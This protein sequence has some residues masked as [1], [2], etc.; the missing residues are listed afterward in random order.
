MTLATPALAVHVTPR[1]RQLR[2][3]WLTVH[4]WTA[5]SVGW[6]LALVGLVGAVLI[7]GQ[8]VD[9]WLHPA[10]FKAQPAAASA[11]PATLE[12]IRR[13]LVAEFGKASLRL[14]PPVEPGDTLAV[15]V[16]SAAWDGTVYLHPLTGREQG[17][18]GELEGVVNFLFKFHSSLLLKDTGKATLAAISLT[19]LV[20]LVTGLLLWWPKRW[21]PT[22]RV[23]L[24]KGLVRGLFDL[25][26]TGGAVLGLVIAV[27]VTSGAYMAWRPLAQAVD[28][29]AGV[30]PVKPP[31]VPKL[32][33]GQDPA[34]LPLD[35][36]VAIGR[37]AF[38]HDPIGFIQV[39]ATLDQPLRLRMRVA[40]DPHPNGLSSVWV[41]PVTGEVLAVTRWDD[42][43]PGA[44]VVSWMYPLHTGELGGPVLEA[45]M[46]AGGVTFG[47]LGISGI[48]LWWRRRRARPL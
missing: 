46:C 1:K 29:V 42:L 13:Q 26:R 9:R 39:P 41:H 37:A 21:P 48:W 31:K 35:R 36:L 18:R 17:R 5:L 44:R 6:L 32:R 11:A 4:R 20:L 33:P 43:D 30:A 16:T 34:P 45:V 40:G 8:P 47:M 22:L 14:R 24:R 28:T 7:V 10:L 38:P 25:H 3:T 2:R 15:R 19:Y 12:T 27:S 23:E